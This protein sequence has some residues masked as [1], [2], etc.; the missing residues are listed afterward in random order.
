[1]G[2]QVVL[3]FSSGIL[4]GLQSMEGKM[5]SFLKHE[6]RAC[7]SFSTSFITLIFFLC[8]YRALM[9]SS[10][11]FRVSSNFVKMMFLGL[12]SAKSSLCSAIVATESLFVPI[13]VTKKSVDARLGHTPKAPTC[14]CHNPAQ[15]VSWIGLSGRPV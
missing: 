5:A 1:M 4:I 7:I 3:I 6:R 10:T 9:Y 15:P 13:G 2:W 8:S 14:V 12:T 11:I